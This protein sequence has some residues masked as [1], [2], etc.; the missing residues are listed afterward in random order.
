[1]VLAGA[2]AWNIGRDLGLTF[3]LV[4]SLA[5]L[6][7]GAAFGVLA[8]VG[9]GLAIG[10]LARLARGAPR[11]G[12]AVA[13]AIIGLTLSL[14][15]DGYVERNARLQ[16]APL[17]E[18]ARFF[19]GP[20]APSE[21]TP[22]AFS[23]VPDARVAGDRLRRPLRMVARDASCGLYRRH[24]SVLTTSSS[25][26]NAVSDLRLTPG[27]L[28]RCVYRDAPLVRVPAR[29]AIYPPLTAVQG[30]AELETSTSPDR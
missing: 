12:A 10:P 9:L 21:R 1:M 20:A 24:W 27:P 22:V 6:A 19:T 26:L 2:S 28:Q 7:S 23:P 15:A 13:A 5:T 25:V 17:V 30:S 29:I 3:P 11:V 4:P 14:R 8:A 16:A 18:V